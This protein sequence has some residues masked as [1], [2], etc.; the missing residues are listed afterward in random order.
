MGTKHLELD[1]TFF[2]SWKW[3][4]S[5]RG[6]RNGYESGPTT[7]NCF[8][9]TDRQ[10]DRTTDLPFVAIRDRKHHHFVR[11]CKKPL[12]IIEIKWCKYFRIEYKRF[13]SDAFGL[14]ET[15][16]RPAT[17][18]DGPTDRLAFHAPLPTEGQKR[19]TH[20]YNVYGAETTTLNKGHRKASNR[21]R[22]TDRQA[23]LPRIAVPCIRVNMYIIIR[24]YIL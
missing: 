3:V 24:V 23:D 16:P 6:R 18:F 21:L 9:L 20:W 7:S 11:K 4:K 17:V 13:L 5:W 2:N 8:P 14:M 19:H 12:N 1:W 15:I 22:L 10:S